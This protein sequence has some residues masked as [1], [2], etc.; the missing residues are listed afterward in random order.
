MSA[1]FIDFRC[2]DPVASTMNQ[3]WYRI[4]DECPCNPKL[5]NQTGRGFTSCPLGVQFDQKEINRVLENPKIVTNNNKQMSMSDMPSGSLF[6]NVN[7]SPDVVPPNIQPRALIRIGQ[8]WRSGW[9]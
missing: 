4:L 5:S 8:S 7:N 9:A 6:P 2:I 1:N 3:P